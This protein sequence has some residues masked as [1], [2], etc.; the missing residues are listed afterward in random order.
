MQRELNRNLVVEASY[1]A[2]RGVWWGQGS[3]LSAHNVISEQLLAKYGFTNFNSTAERDLLTT[4]IANLSANQRTILASR[5][6]NLPYA[7]FPTSQTVRQ[8]LL[9]FRSSPAPS[10]R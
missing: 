10:A 1:V 5:G 2:N 7:G 4:N 8:S 9:P 3:A 6:V